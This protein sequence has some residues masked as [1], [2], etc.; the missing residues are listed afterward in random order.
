MV[1]QYVHDVLKHAGS[2]SAQH[3]L[4]E[5]QAEI[6]KAAQQAQEIIIE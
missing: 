1:N 6:I 3:V 5:E 4:T 2:E